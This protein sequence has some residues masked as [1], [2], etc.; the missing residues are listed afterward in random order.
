MTDVN[1]NM[2]TLTGTIFP[3]LHTLEITQNAG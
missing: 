1:V 2:N 3:G